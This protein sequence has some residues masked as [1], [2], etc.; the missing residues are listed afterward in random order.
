M[1][2]AVKAGGRRHGRDDSPIRL[3]LVLIAAIAIAEVIVRLLMRQLL[4]PLPLPIEALLDLVLLVGLLYPVLYSQVLSPLLRQITERCLAEEQLK[5]S[6][7]EKDM[8]L[9]EVHHRVKNNLQVI[10]GLLGLQA[11]YVADDHHARLFGDSQNRIATLALI[12]E[13]LSDSADLTRIELAVYIRHLLA[14]LYASLGADA[15]LLTVE[16]E[17]DAVTLDIDRAVPCAL[18]INELVSNA[19]RFAFPDNRR[20]HVRVAL[21][22]REDGRMLLRVKDD[23]V[24]FPPGWDQTTVP[25]LGLRLVAILVKQLEGT[26]GIVRSPGVEYMIE[27]HVNALQERH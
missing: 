24:G 1:Y 17:A 18:I 7:R 15:A 27:F 8:L 25:S 10:S 12:Y 22:R 23:G 26:M 20:G 9:K 13:V 11:D 5:D 2:K 6:M 21:E 16:V 4:V 19:F 14:H 3:F